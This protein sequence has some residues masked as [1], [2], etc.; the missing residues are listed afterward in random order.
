MRKTI[1]SGTMLCALIGAAALVGGCGGSSN[2]EPTKLSLSISEQGKTASFQAPKT[3]KGGLVEVSLKNAGQAPH[4]LQ[5]IQY[6]GDHTVA[7]VQKQLQSNS[8]KVPDWLRA[9]GGIGSVNPGASQTATVN[10]PAGNYLL[11]DAATA[12]GPG[13]GS[14]PPATAPMTFSSGDTGDLPDTPGKVVANEVGKD[15]F[16][17]D[18]SGLHSGQNDI[19]FE[20]KGDE[21]L[22]LIIA[23]PVNGT[24]PPL[25]QIQSDFAKAGHGPPPSYLDFK[26]AQSSAILDGGL[27]QTTKL[28]LQKPGQYIFFC[29]LTDR[30]GGK[31]HDQEGLLKVA[32]VN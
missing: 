19:T 6:T 24:A 32:T 10:L 3:A 23:V 31:S 14:G 5:F 16:A 7:D 4:G 30:D 21:A 22:H 9:E 12:F 28:N 17:W 15:K 11:V 27:S 20:A 8:N 29:P 26:D 18:L 13:A 25:S 1:V 2:P